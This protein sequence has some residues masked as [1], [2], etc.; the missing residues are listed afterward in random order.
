MDLLNRT[1]KCVKCGCKICQMKAM[2]YIGYLKQLCNKCRKKELDKIIKK[3]LKKEMEK[4]LVIARIKQIPDN[5]K[6]SI[7]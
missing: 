5:F 2:Y 1:Q 3:S 4:E 6:L 7:G